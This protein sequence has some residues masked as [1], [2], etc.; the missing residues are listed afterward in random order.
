MLL[1]Y[2]HDQNFAQDSHLELFPAS[3]DYYPFINSYSEE[4]GLIQY[5]LK[6]ETWIRNNS[7]PNFGYEGDLKNISVQYVT[8]TV[9]SKPQLFVFSKTSGDFKFYELTIDGWALNVNIPIGKITIKSKSIYAR[10]SPPNNDRS[11]YIFSYS[12]DGQSIAVL[13]RVENNWQHIK[14]FPTELPK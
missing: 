12:S 10:Y 14:Y 7:I 4:E 3:N 11:S 5:Y 1:M 9:G 6:D 8:N 13:E 2:M